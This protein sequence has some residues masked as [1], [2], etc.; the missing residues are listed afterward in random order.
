MN[1]MRHST[2]IQGLLSTVLWHL[3]YM[4]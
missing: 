4:Y 2:S 3:E 1:S